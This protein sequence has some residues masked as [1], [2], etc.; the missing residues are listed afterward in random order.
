MT[1]PAPVL[2][3]SSASLPSSVSSS[4]NKSK[5]VDILKV[6]A[7]LFV[8]T[9]FTTAGTTRAHTSDLKTG[10]TNN[11]SCLTGVGLSVK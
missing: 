2:A 1:T 7:P 4:N 10:A 3:S 8:T 11:T 9:V 6:S 5:P